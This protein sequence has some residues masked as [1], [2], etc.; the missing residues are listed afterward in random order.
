MSRVYVSPA[1]AISTDYDQHIGN[2]GIGIFQICPQARDERMS[3][4]SNDSKKR[5]IEKNPFKITYD[6]WFQ[7]ASVL[8]EKQT[9]N[10][11]TLFSVW[12]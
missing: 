5:Y 10:S 7:D 9:K 11:E 2:R 1:E 8:W 4:L 6:I 3:V 12:T